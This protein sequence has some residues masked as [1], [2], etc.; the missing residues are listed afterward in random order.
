M[1][2]DECTEILSQLLK[3]ED[4]KAFLRWIKLSDHHG[5]KGGVTCRQCADSDDHFRSKGYYDSH[6]RRVVLCA[7]NIS[8]LDSQ[9]KDKHLLYDRTSSHKAE[10]RKDLKSTLHHELVH[11][12]DATYLQAV[13]MTGGIGESGTGNTVKDQNTRCRK[14]LCTEIRASL[15]GQCSKLVDPL[16]KKACVVRDVLNSVYNE[17]DRSL[18]NNGAC[19]NCDVPH[20]LTEMMKTCYNTKPFSN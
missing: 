19:F 12:F 10:Y 9:Y 14:L 5:L 16:R 3:E 4:T 18:R 2:V 1:Q 15:S 13:S 8:R 6:N 7:D 17:S 11:A 20:L